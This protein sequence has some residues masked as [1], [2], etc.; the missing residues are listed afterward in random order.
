MIPLRTV[1]LLSLG[2]LLTGDRPAFPAEPDPLAADVALLRSASVATDG[3]GLLEFFRKRTPG[4]SDKAKIAALIRNLGDE[5]F[6]VREKATAQLV[7]VGPVASPLLRDAVKDPDVEV[8]RRAEHCLAAIE[9]ASGA[10]Y[11]AAAARVL[12]HR[13]PALATEV[14]LAYLPN[15]EDVTVI[16]TVSTALAAVGV[17]GGKPEPALV[18]ALDDKLPLKRAVAGEAL[19]RAGGTS[20]RPVVRELLHDE[21]RQV[22][23]RVAL[24]LLEAR[25]KDAVPVLIRLLTE[26]PQQQ[27][28]RVEDA[29]IRIAGDQAPEAP[30]GG[31][32]GRA[33]YREAW[34][35][36]WEKQGPTL[37]LAKVEPGKRL[38]GHTL[39]TMLELRNAQLGR[40][41]ELDATGKVRW[42]LEGLSYPVDAQVLGEDRVLVAEY[43]GKV[44]TER[45]LK[46]E[47][48]WQKQ[49]SGLLLGARRL[50]N[51][52]TFLVTRNQLLEVDKDDKEVLNVSR[53]N[54]VAVATKLRD[55]H[56][57]LVTTGGQYVRLD[58]T[59]KEVKSFPVGNVLPMGGN[60]EVLPNGR[61]LVPLYSLNKVVEFDGE[62]RQVWEAAVQQPASVQRLPNGNTLVAQRLSPNIV[63]LDRNGKEVATV[64]VEG[65]ALRVSRR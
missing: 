60:I 64:K 31:D 56:I 46:N 55:G 30:V 59:G 43:R 29:L 16:D 35:A 10:T 42:Q 5:D 18:A 3:P 63:E 4:E 54:D 48:V 58:A 24:A 26:L 36:W 37:D 25:D 33:K 49:V 44:V 39:V 34:A 57:A 11:M 52:N 12:A 61:V 28:W 17:P 27:V 20:Q 13:K 19:A 47:V 51:G 38:Q 8:A 2:L 14:L 15:A 21:D 7:T 22:R 40:V 32:K 50:P 45:N 41:V 6:S 23:E 62:G 65:R 1:A 53:P 9:K